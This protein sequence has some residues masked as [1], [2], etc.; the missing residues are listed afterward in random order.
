MRVRH[1]HFCLQ[2]GITSALTALTERGKD[3]SITGKRAASV[4]SYATDLLWDPTHLPEILFASL[5]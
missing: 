3:G 5:H 1:T 4:H 2:L